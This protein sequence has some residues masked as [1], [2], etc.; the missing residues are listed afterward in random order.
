[1]RSKKEGVKFSWHARTHNPGTH[2][3]NKIFLEGLSFDTETPFAKTQTEHT[4]FL[5][6]PNQEKST[7]L[8]MLEAE[9]SHNYHAWSRLENPRKA[10]DETFRRFLTRACVWKLFRLKKSSTPVT[11]THTQ[12][13]IDLVQSRTS[14]SSIS[15]PESEG[16]PFFPQKR[17]R[18]RETP[19]TTKTKR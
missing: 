8:R 14:Q 12:R 9:T 4:H 19:Q 6:L 5:T 1:M 15:Q 2:I 3:K 10:Y 13:D 18:E 7:A 17:E 16:F 11:N